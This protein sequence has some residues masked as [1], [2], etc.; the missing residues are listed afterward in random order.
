M[1]AEPSLSDVAKFAENGSDESDEDLLWAHDNDEIM[2]AKLERSKQGNGNGRNG[3]ITP[4]KL[5]AEAQKEGYGRLYAAFDGGVAGLQA[6][7]AG[8]TLFTS[9][10]RVKYRSLGQSEF[11]SWQEYNSKLDSN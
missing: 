1:I 8:T 6:C 4:D 10:F 2:A 7:A 3:S 5:E 11:R 9:G